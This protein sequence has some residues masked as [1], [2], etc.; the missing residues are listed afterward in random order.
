MVPGALT[1]PSKYKG[2]KG[3][4]MIVGPDVPTGKKVAGLIR[5]RAEVFRGA[6]RPFTA[7]VNQ[8]LSEVLNSFIRVYLLLP[9]SIDGSEPDVKKLVDTSLYF[10][11]GK[12]QNRTEVIYYPD[13]SR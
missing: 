1:E 12:A 8:E 3:T 11:S 6:L 4:I 10:A 7:T 5:A 9:G 13:E 2:S